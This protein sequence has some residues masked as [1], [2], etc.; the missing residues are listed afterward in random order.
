MQGTDALVSPPSTSRMQSKQLQT[1]M[2]GP[3]VTNSLPSASNKA[4]NYNEAPGG[5]HGSPKIPASRLSRSSRRLGWL[6]PSQLTHAKLLCFRRTASSD[7]KG[8]RLRHRN[9]GQ[10]WNPDQP[11]GHGNGHHRIRSS[12]QPDR[13]RHE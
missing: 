1:F 11:P 5:Q 13:T 3:A 2:K 8:R 4:I 12:F 6:A 9:P 7:P 10:N